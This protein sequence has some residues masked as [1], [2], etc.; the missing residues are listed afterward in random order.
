MMRMSRSTTWR[1]TTKNKNKKNKK[2]KKN[3]ERVK[4]GVSHVSLLGS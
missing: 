1:R 3:A 2:N 4:E